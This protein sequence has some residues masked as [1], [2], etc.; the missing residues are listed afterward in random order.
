MSETHRLLEAANALSQL[1]RSHSI[2]HAFHGSI[3]TAVVSDSPRCD[4]SVTVLT[5]SSQRAY[6]S[7]EIYCIVDGGSTHPFRR[8]RQALVGNDHF[9]ITHSPWSNRYAWV[10]THAVIESYASLGCMPRIVD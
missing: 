8:V 10:V 7:Q 6:S 9:T 2:P 4:V 1:L 3:L 5:P